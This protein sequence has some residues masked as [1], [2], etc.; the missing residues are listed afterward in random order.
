MIHADERLE[1]FALPGEVGMAWLTD[2]PELIQMYVS[3]A[4]GD[5]RDLARLLGVCMAQ[6]NAFRKELVKTLHM[7]S[8]VTATASEACGR[9]Q[10]LVTTAN[11][12]IETST[13]VDRAIMEV[14]GRDEEG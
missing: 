5:A 14:E 8:A 4:E 3:R 6:R 1:G 13:E 10:S 7:L 11:K 2:R 9:V 12:H